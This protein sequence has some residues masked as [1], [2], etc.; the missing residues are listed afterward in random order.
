MKS[1]NFFS[2]AFCLERV[3]GKERT[4]NTV[5]RSLSGFGK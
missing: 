3:Q 4:S 2:F 1:I 5:G